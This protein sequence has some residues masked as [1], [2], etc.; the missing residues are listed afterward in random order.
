MSRVAAHARA[1]VRLALVGATTLGLATVGLG[2]R[3]LRPVAPRRLRRAELRVASQWGAVLVRILGVRVATTG[4]PPPAPALLVA[5][6]LSYVDIL[7]LLRS[8]PAVFVARADMAGWPGLGSLA[9][10]AGTH[11]VDR[12]RRRDLPRVIDAIAGTLR[13]GSSV[14]FFPEGT[15]SG[16]EEV[17]PFHAPLF[18]ASIRSGVPISVASIRYAVEGSTAAAS[19][20]VCW[21]GTMT[22]PDHVYRLLQLRRVEATLRFGD[23]QLRD[24]QRDGLARAAR[25]AVVELFGRDAPASSGRVGTPRRNLASITR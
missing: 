5:N 6:H 3:A 7:V 21:W 13:E 17:L 22:F 23:L 12:T 19:E 18:E 10:L 2:V 11:F 8:C 1:L 24:A 9:R 15:S 25:D 16:G 20:R 4:A 14:V